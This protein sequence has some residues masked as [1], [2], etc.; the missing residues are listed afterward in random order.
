MA[1]PLSEIAGN[2]CRRRVRARV[3]RLSDQVK[4]VTHVALFRDAH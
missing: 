1:L 3:M 4:N 2:Y